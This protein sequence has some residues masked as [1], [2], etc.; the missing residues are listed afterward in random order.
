MGERI[1]SPLGVIVALSLLS[2]SLPA[3]HTP[4]S[5][6]RLNTLNFYPLYIETKVTDVRK[7]LVKIS[8]PC[9]KN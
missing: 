6:T 7:T 2:S 4:I 5:Y 8:V 9:Q 3:S 1:G